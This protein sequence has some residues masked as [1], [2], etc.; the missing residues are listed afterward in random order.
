[1]TPQGLIDTCRD[2]ADD[3]A[4]PPLWSDAV[5]MIHAAEGELE[6]ARRTRVLF[7]TETADVCEIDVT[8]TPIF[9]VD[10]RVIF[11]RRVKLDGQ[12]LPLP[13]VS[14]AAL[15]AE[16]PGWDNEEPNDPECWVPWGV[17]QIRL[18]P[19]PAEADTLRLHVVREP[20]EAIALADPDATPTPLAAVSPEIQPRYHMGIVKW[21]LHRAFLFRERQDMYRPEESARYLSE[22]EEEFGKRSAAVDEIWIHRKHGYDEYEGLR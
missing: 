19:E 12:E 5:W 9:D 18:V 7:D 13:K 22:F 16:R 11:V 2:L 1:M 8:A 3:H 4:E 10:P 6:I 17:N 21:M 20:L 14:I 15:D